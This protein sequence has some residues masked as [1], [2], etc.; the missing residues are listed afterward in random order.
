MPNNE[1][2]V[3][4][5]GLGVISPN[6]I[7]LP[8]FELALRQGKSGIRFLEEL[9]EKNFACQIGGKPEVSDTLK[10]KYFSPVQVKMLRSES[11]IFGTLA[12]LEAWEHA[13]FKIP[14][15]KDTLP[16]WDTGCIMGTGQAA[17]EIIKRNLYLINEGNVRRLGSG[18]VDQGM[19]SGVSAHLGG[20]LGLGNQV[21][22]NASACATGTE[23]ILNGYERIRSGLARRMI[24][25]SCESPDP[26]VW[27][28]FDSMRVLTR[29]YND[30]PEAG[31][32]P[33]SA[34]ASGF[35]PGGGA[36]ALVIES[37]E[38][39]LERGAKIYGEILG[40]NIN[41]GG[42][43]GSGSMTAPNGEG[44]QRCIQ[45]ALDFCKIS[46]DEIDAISGHLTSTMADPQ[47]ITNWAKALKRK[48]K[49]FPY[50]HSLKSM[51]GHCLSAAGAIESVAALLQLEK[52]FFH[53]SLNSEDIHPEIAQI[54][55][56]D[57]IP[58]QLVTKTDFNIIAKSSFGFGD[59]N[60][61]IIFK[62]WENN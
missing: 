11:I 35:V 16:D 20:I 39:A 31:S 2:R 38:T 51:I 40:G 17:G 54:V 6:A 52:G 5:T 56:A 45:G 28:G 18:A 36:G 44:V 15:D 59:V 34:S 4:V 50:I 32:R 60:T 13:G 33:M 14:A 7:G 46:A 25:G 8:A 1:I 30:Q 21:T 53:A 43:R 55:D 57:K 24:V 27:G 42:Q 62:R 29:K 37:L 23:A 22:T 47:E 61:C 49:N 48:G 3:V 12:G 19:I 58:Q 10:E 9:A 41:S 26:F